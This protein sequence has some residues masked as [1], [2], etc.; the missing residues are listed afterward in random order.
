MA[1]INT[2]NAPPIST[3][4]IGGGSA[5]STSNTVDGSY[6]GQRI[7]LLKNPTAMLEDA[8][9]ELS[10]THS[11]KVEK[12]LAKRKMGKS[13]ALKTFAM[14]Q[15]E[16]YLKQVP[17]LERNKKLKDFADQIAQMNKSTTAQQLREAARQFSKDTTHQFLALSY[18]I[19]QLKE[20]GGDEALLSSLNRALTELNEESGPE[21]R[22][23]LNV[24]QAAAEAAQKGLGEIQDLRDSYRDAVLNF[25]SISQ[26]YKKITE[27]RGTEKL[28]ASVEFLLKGLSTEVNKDTRSLP[29]Q[30][31]KAI[32]D[33]IYQLKLLSSMYYQCDDLMSRLKHNYPATSIE[34]G[35]ALLQELLR[36]KENSW[37]SGQQIQQISDQLKISL[38]EAKIYFLTGLKDL[39]RLIPFKS[40]DSD[41]Q[42][43][44]LLDSVQQ[45]LD[46]AIDEEPPEEA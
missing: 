21:I 7:G 17:D 37:H 32:M 28:T 40:F 15:A 11:E 45:A 12:K 22:A 27:E 31:L 3:Q 6:N 19:E 24:S 33:D 42:R 41:N 1:D 13:T 26:V 36:L 8:A 35:Q 5:A 20:E 30:Q 29:K 38:P 44:E 34:D 25:T 46:A 9:E 18:T 10:F 2:P 43:A 23:G 16:L 14:K 39:I 4:N